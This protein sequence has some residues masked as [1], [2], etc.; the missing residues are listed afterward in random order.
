MA[1][2]HYTGSFTIEAALIM[3]MILGVI[4]LFINISM[5]SFDRCAIE[6]ICHTACLD[7]VYEE[8]SDLWAEDY[9]RTQLDKRLICK[10]DTDV[11][12]YSDEEA[13]TARVEAKPRVFDR[14]FVYTVKA[15]KLFCPKY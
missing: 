3:P 2:K 7:A 5:V 14:T 15:N 9:I 11:T 13:V 4:V 1:C 12:V 8:D 6:Y 10:W